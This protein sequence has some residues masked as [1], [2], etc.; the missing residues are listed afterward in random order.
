VT[1]WTISAT[2]WVLREPDA[3]RAAA[4]I[5]AAGYTAVELS[6]DPD[7]GAS[8]LRGAAI[9]N[10]LEVTSLCSTWSAD[11]DCAHPDPAL[12]AAARE[13]LARSAELAGELGA[14]LIVV[15]PTYRTAPADDREAELARAADTI[16]AAAA[17]IP[18]GG[19]TLALEA[20]N[21][22]ETHLVRTLEDAETLR[23][24][25]AHPQVRLMADL[26]HMQVEEDE[27]PAALRAH[28]AQIVH[29]HLADDQRR[30]PGSGSLD[31]AAA[32]A[33]LSD[34]GYAGA[35]TMEFTPATD[36]AL[37]AGREHVEHLT[38][39]A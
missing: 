30:E 32:F 1:A 10:G 7:A 2:Q 27:T 6:A 14:P 16:A 4:R 28:A 3:A 38:G 8:A 13:Y 26:F 31:F 34:V 19:P 9:E 29:V 23:A 33:A 37:R 35:L 12:R 36:A 18:A 20:L 5:A 11:R 21:R 24:A 15:V 17:T 22:S 39:A 25:I